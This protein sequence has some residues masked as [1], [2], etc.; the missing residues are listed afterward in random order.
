MS[1]LWGALIGLSIFVVV[2][3][4]YVEW[5]QGICDRCNALIAI[6]Q[7]AAKRKREINSF[8]YAIVDICKHCENLEALDRATKYG[9]SE[10]EYIHRMEMVI[11]EGHEIRIEREK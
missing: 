3:G 7:R 6:R 8:S 5:V 1:L 10:V 9:T 11:G 4:A 2:F